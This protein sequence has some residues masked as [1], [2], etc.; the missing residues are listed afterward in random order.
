MEGVVPLAEDGLNQAL[1][2]EAVQ[3]TAVP[4]LLIVKV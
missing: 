1:A 4:V 3:L 2:C